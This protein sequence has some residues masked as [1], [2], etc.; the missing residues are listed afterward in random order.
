MKPAWKE[1]LYQKFVTNWRVIV[2][3]LIENTRKTT[4]LFFRV[5]PAATLRLPSAKREGVDFLC[6]G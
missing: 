5:W 1:C 6:D 4:S 3:D 2:S